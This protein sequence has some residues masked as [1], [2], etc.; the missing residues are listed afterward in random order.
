MS[1]AAILSLFATTELAIFSQN[2]FWIIMGFWALCI[3]VLPAVMRRDFHKVLP[4]E[5][6]LLITLPFYIFTALLFLGGADQSAFPNLM[7]AAE[8]MATFLIALLTIMDLHVYTEFHTNS[9]F[10]VLLTTLT[11]MALSSVFAIANFLSDELFGTQLLRNNN[12]LMVNLL[13]SFL[14]GVAMGFFLYL[15]LKKMP[16]TRLERYSIGRLGG[17]A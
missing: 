16:L 5:L 7:R 3:A 10:A 14:G 8:V 6:L 9:A 13:F 12:E 15:Y 4:F 1:W 17:G 2:P 11:T